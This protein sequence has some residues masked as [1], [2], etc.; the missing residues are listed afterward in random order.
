M[1]RCTRKVLVLALVSGMM[2]H[3]SR[4]AAG[5]APARNGFYLRL[6]AGAGWLLDSGEAKD[7]SGVRV[8]GTIAGASLCSE[9]S[10]AGAV[11]PGLFVGAFASG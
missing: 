6:G 8:S 3:S 7:Y 9:L 10:M 2:A 11:M 1:R 5:E 4:G